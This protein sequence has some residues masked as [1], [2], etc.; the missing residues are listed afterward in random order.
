[1]GFCGKKGGDNEVGWGGL[2]GV[3]V[4]KKCFFIL[5]LKFL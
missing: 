4:E 1:M 3:G 2:K 5:L